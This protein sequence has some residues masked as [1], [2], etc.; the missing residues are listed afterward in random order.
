M[1]DKKTTE[2]ILQKNIELIYEMIMIIDK[3]DIKDEYD[4]AIRLLLCSIVNN[5]EEGYHLIVMNRNTGIAN[6]FR[7][8]LEGLVYLASI[9]QDDN[10]L[11]VI[12]N[13]DYDELKKIRNDY[14]QKGISYSDRNIDEE[15]ATIKERIKD[16][17]NLINAYSNLSYNDS[18]ERLFNNVNM[19][20]EY[21]LYFRFFSRKSHPNIF[22][23]Q[24]R[25]TSS[26]GRVTKPTI[27]KTDMLLYLK[28]IEDYCN[29]LI[30]VITHEYKLPENFIQNFNTNLKTLQQY[31]LGI[32]I[33]MRNNQNYNSTT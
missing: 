22:E 31:Y 33:L 20:M 14:K 30:D 27:T 21:T 5:I 13:R 7:T 32:A 16:N 9:A 25:Y 18:R 4:S 23:I 28:F 3:N 17:Q 15:I 2:K 29:K 26:S 11:Y 12:K 1:I 10:M 6:Y 19:R 24:E 8:A